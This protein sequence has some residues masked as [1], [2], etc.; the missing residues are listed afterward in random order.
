MPERP[1]RPSECALAI[2]I[3][4]SREEL[5]AGARSASPSDY[6]RQS[7]GEAAS[8]AAEIGAMKGLVAKARAWG[9]EV[10][11]GAGLDDLARLTASFHVV[12]VIAHA[13]CPGV[14]AGDI[15][16]VGALLGAARAGTTAD[17][18]RVRR[19]LRFA[20][21][22]RGPGAPL[23]TAEAVSAALAGL[24]W[25]QR[26]ERGRRVGQLDRTRLE[27]A[28]P[29]SFHPAPVLE[30]RDGL[31]TLSAVRAAIAPGFHGVLDLSVCRSA[32]L[33]EA[34]KRTRDDFVVLVTA[35]PTQPKARLALYEIRM[36][37]LERTPGKVRFTDVVDTVA[38]AF[39]LLSRTW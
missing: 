33:G 34:L 17:Q 35:A 31:H 28:F 29:A 27:D 3:P 1:V 30:L 10:V 23:P 39:L 15:R 36:S 25:T 21:V 2:G 12:T 6:A 7:A 16:D 14:D 5:L 24:L 13:P 9:V 37:E 32:V 18:K 26:A 8:Y 22:D 4:A 38:D 20:G 19:F 11:E